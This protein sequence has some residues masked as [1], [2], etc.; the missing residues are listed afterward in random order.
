MTDPATASLDALS[1]RPNPTD[2]D[3]AWQHHLGRRPGA[4]ETAAALEAAGGDAAALHEAAFSHPEAVARAT[5]PPMQPAWKFHLW[6]PGAARLLVLGNC[7]A[8]NLARA[9]GWLSQRE[10]SIAGLDITAFR[11]N[12]EEFLRAAEGADVILAPATSAAEFAEISVEALRGAGRAEVVPYVPVH[13]A[14][15]FPDITYLGAR[16]ERVLSPIGDYNSRIVV[17]SFL[18]GL[19]PAACLAAFNVETYAEQ[20]HFAAF[21]AAE[22]EWERRES[23]L[24]ADGLSLRAWFFAEIRERP[25]LYSTNHPTGDFFAEFARQFGRRIGLPCAT[26]SSHGCPNTLAYGA[27]WPIPAELAAHHGLR[28][29]TPLVWSNNAYLLGAEEF[30]WRSYRIY[31]R[32][33]RAVLEEAA[34]SRGIVF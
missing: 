1:V 15:L 28:Y 16:G 6:R 27:T 21:A 30:V 33:D 24:G 29:S 9:V 22:R 32:H 26:G 14:G 5:L 7:Q 18:R 13:F 4:E 19:D 20:G 25:L 2:V 10:V 31:A 8:P 23:R 11:R 3:W 34:R 17:R 12:R